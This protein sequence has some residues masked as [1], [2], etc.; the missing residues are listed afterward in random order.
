MEDGR[1]RCDNG[2]AQGCLPHLRW[3]I[4]QVAAYD[5][6][7]EG[8]SSIAQLICEPHTFFSQHTSQHYHTLWS[9][10]MESVRKD[11][12]CTFG[13]LKCRF[14]ILSNPIPYVSHSFFLC[15]YYY[16]NYCNS[17]AEP[18]TITEKRSTM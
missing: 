15:V 10:Q 5:M 8:V 7:F 1:H 17:T 9:V 13:I 6:R 11:V 14:K 3:R 2:A 16:S 18:G 4:P 12:E